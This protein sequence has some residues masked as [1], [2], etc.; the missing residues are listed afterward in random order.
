[1]TNNCKLSITLL[2]P[3]Q[4]SEHTTL[5]ISQ[6]QAQGLLDLIRQKYATELANISS[7]RPIPNNQ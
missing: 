4:R 1:M 2:N 7:D 6:Q 3:G 5:E